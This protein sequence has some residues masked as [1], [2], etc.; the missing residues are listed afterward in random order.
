MTREHSR[1]VCANR[2]S[3]SDQTTRLFAKWIRGSMHAWHE[4]SRPQIHG[5]DLNCI[6]TLGTSQF[7][8]G[9]D[10]KLLR[11][12]AEPR[13]V[14]QVLRTLCRIEGHDE[15]SLPDA[16][17]IPALG[18]S[19][20]SIPNTL[21]EEKTSDDA[22]TTAGD[23]AD[24]GAAPS[25]PLQPNQPPTE[26]HLARQTLWPE[27]EKLYGHGFEIST[28]A[29]SHD[30]TL[31]ATACRASSVQHAVIRLYETQGWR[32]VKP[33]L[34]AHNL[35]VTR[36][37]FSD[38]DQYLLSV[39]RDRQWFLFKRDM[40]D[41][42][43]YGSFAHNSRGHGRMLLDAAWAPN[44]SGCERM[45]ATAGRDKLVSASTKAQT[46]L[47]LHPFQPISKSCLRNETNRSRS[48]KSQWTSTTRKLQM[49][50]AEQPYQRRAPSPPSPFCIR[51][52]A[53]TPCT[54]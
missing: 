48:G 11:V 28:L 36:L 41:R 27:R 45:F 4:L 10:E 50:P 40:Q 3:S 6:D 12:F 34:T 24:N 53:T 43:L 17:G 22:V 16:A 39:G 23:R 25:Q 8:S 9:A 32:E 52:A 1:V 33:A 21:D 37:R 38:D 20:K 15:D 42:Q 49:F 44:G 30:G 19:N 7:V 47:S 13:A 51:R 5:Y 14:A 18:L 26:D 54:S 46:L 35:T 2:E 31:V 29:T